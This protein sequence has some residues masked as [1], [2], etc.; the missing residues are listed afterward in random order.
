M[1]WYNNLDVVPFVKAI[2]ERSKLYDLDMFQ[3]GLSLPSVSEKM[4]HSIDEEYKE[5]Y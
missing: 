2:Q 1:I 3:D 4:I 5:I